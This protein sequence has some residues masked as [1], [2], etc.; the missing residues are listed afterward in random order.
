MFLDF[1]R[2]K[3]VKVL[4]DDDI[5]VFIVIF[6]RNRVLIFN[7]KINVLSYIF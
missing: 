4:E 3:F 2:F 1:Y 6:S 5:F 7:W